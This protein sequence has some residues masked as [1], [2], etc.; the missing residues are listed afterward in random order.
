MMDAEGLTRMTKRDFFRLFWKAY[1]KAFEPSNIQS[2]W[3]KTGLHPF[4]PEVILDKFT[5]KEAPAEERPS[6]SESSK[7]ILA[8]QDWRKIEKMLKEVVADIFDKRVR[9]L[10]DTIQNLATTNIL[11]ETRI[12]G[13][14]RALQNEQK[15]RQR[16]KPLFHRLAAAEDG[17]AIFYSPSKVQAARE[18]QKEEQQTKEAAIALKAEEKLQRQLQKEEKR[19]LVEQRKAQRVQDKQQRQKEAEAKKLA[20]Q[21]AEEAKQAE[22]Q[23]QNDIKQARRLKRNQ[24]NK[25]LATEEV[26]LDAVDD[27][28]AQEAP[29]AI[30]RPRRQ[31]KLPAKLQD[32]KL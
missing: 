32:C 3:E 23:L 25:I 19:H 14:Q 7:S 10:N 27:G 5:V 12:T 30:G 2:G 11:L 28:E 24:N 31:K 22:L 16:A 4:A 1:N 26:D 9:T 21:E 13:Y 17:K 15:K 29:P 18:L 8:A 20:A 6:S